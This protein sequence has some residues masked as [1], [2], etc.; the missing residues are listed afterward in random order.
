MCC[1]AL[2]NAPACPFLHA[3]PA[4]LRRTCLAGHPTGWWPL[5][6]TRRAE[7]G[8]SLVQ[9]AVGPCHAL[10]SG[11]PAVRRRRIAKQFAPRASRPVRSSAVSQNGN[12]V[13]SSGPP[14][15]YWWSATPGP[16]TRHTDITQC[17]S[18]VCVT[19]SPSIPPYRTHYQY[20][21]AQATPMACPLS[22]GTFLGH[23]MVNT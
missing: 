7:S 12:R 4:F 19:V 6:R 11:G 8:C 3:C 1:G 5:R 2:Q 13:G 14:R 20:I 9:C 22:T 21:V 16:T 17:T 23:I 18:A 15:T 10:G